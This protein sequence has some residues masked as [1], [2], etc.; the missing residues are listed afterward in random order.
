[1][2]VAILGAGNGGICIGACMALR[3]A[4]VALYDKFP[5][6]LAP[7]Q[8]RGGVEL[9]GVSLTGFARFAK[10]SDNLPEVVEG[11]EL[12]MAITPAFAHRELAELCGPQLTRGQTVILNPGRTCGAIEFYNTARARGATGFRVAEA[13]SLIYAC[14]VTGPAEGTIYSVKREMELAA[15]P[16]RDT[17]KVLAV[18]RQFYPQFTAAANVLETSIMNI[19]A[20]FHPA[21]ALL[22]IARI[23]QKAP[24]R[25]YLDGIS[26][27]VGNVIQ[28]IDDERVA[29][30]KA[31]GVK[32]MTAKEWLVSVYAEDVKP[33]DTLYLSIQKQGAYAKV[34]G[35]TDP[36]AR[37]ITEDIPMSLVPLSEL[38][39]LLGVPTPAMDCVIALGSLAHQ[40][41]Y[42]ASGR[43]LESLG[44]L[45]LDKAQLLDFVVNG[46]P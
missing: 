1:M 8:E 15:L 44:L 18:I 16:A 27:C 7:I 2:R 32:T 46:K 10:V 26:P 30:A 24:F 19:G 9:K 17:D 4:E 45:G 21:P 11:A 13:Q 20:I 29:I 36:R 14:R 33:E 35:A 37:Y 41:D 25:H 5:K 28:A 40:R 23:E 39:R 38:G 42:R 43:T 3:G 22:N 12:I 34:M 31:A 6:A